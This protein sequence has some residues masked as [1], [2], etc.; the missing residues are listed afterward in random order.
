MSKRKLRNLVEEGHVAGWD[1]PRMPTLAAMRRRGY[2]PEAIRDFC[3]RAG[4]AKRDGVSEIEQ[5]EHSVRED[6]N[7]RALRVMAVL[8]PLRVVIDNYPEGQVEEMEAINNPEDESA[9]VRRVPFSR[10]LYIEREDFMEDPPP[11]FYR[12]SPG[13]EVRLRYAYLIKCTQVIK[14]AKGEVIEVHCTYDPESRGGTPADGR[15]VKA[16]LHWVSAEHALPAEVR[17]Y[18]RLFTK[19]HPEE[20]EGT[21]FRSFLNQ[22]SLAVLTDCRVEP[23]LGHTVPGDRLQFERLGYFATDPDSKPG[24]P[25]FNRTVSLRDEWTKLQKSGKTS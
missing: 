12:L 4:V 24:K 18:E 9:G 6:L 14:D 5:L 1:D 21:D 20:D 7:R 17:L 10:V 15:R 22:A 16:T 13:R 19:P 25:V 11:K 3:A 2:P 23:S 8:R